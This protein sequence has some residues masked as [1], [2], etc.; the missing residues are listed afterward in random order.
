MSARFDGVGGAR[1]R[2]M[3]AETER[4]LDTCRALQ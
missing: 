4:R 1:F 2:Q 3:Q